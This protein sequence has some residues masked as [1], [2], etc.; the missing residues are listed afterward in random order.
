MENAF[1]MGWGHAVCLLATV[2][3]LAIYL[4]ISEWHK[5]RDC[6]KNNKNR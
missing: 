3:A 6:N 4:I 2:M 5:W 1:N